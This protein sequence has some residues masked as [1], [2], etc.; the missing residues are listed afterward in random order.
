MDKFPSRSASLLC[1]CEEIAPKPRDFRFCTQLTT[2]YNTPLKRRPKQDLLDSLPYLP[3]NFPNQVQDK[4]APR[5]LS[6][7]SIFAE[8]A[9]A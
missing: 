2:V 8:I 1:L 7:G 9:H 5:H 4:E 3:K 6:Q